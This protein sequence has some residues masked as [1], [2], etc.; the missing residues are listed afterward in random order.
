MTDACQKREARPF[1][2]SPSMFHGLCLFT[3]PRENKTDAAPLLTALTFSSLTAL[4]TDQSI[5]RH[6]QLKSPLTLFLA[7]ARPLGAFFNLLC[8]RV[9]LQ[10]RHGLERVS[11]KVKLRHKQKQSTEQGLQHHPSEPLNSRIFV[12]TVY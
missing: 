2:R 11:A 5:K 10:E 6:H 9:R 7:V 4:L 12:I 3:R 8:A 1:R